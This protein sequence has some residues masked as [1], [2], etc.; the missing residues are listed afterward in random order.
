MDIKN[1]KVISWAEAKK[2]L[3]DKEKNKELVYEQKNALDHLRKFC[4]LPEIK[5]KKIIEE[6]SA[7]ENLKERHVI[8][9]LNFMPENLDELRTLFS[10]DRIVLSDDDSKKIVKIVKNNK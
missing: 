1:E 3:S 10:N 4:K 7:I 8:G 6:L 5:S 9:I 2:I